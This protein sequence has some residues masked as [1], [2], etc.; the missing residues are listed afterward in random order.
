MDP[1]TTTSTALYIAAAAATTA[2]LMWLRISRRSAA[3]AAAACRPG[4]AASSSTAASVSSRIAGTDAPC[5]V[6]MQQMLK[7]APAPP[8]SLAQGIVHWQPPAAALDAARAALDLP[9]TSAYG[10]DDG[11]PDLR[12]K[13]V[14]KLRDE[15]GLT[16][17]EVMVTTGANQAFVNVVLSLLDAG[18]KA[19]LFK[20][21]YFNH[22]MAL[23]MTGAGQ[24]SREVRAISVLPLFGLQFAST[25][26]T[27]RV[28]LSGS[29]VRF[30]LSLVGV[31]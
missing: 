21:Y 7:N 3:A 20:P 14:E 22:H 15:N 28:D 18:D 2:T 1:A 27:P 13:L 31:C 17:S 9:Q 30:F 23:Q 19:V 24:P 6:G 29:S 26:A 25:Q 8:L 10:P 4:A 11:H 5:I 16:R 12:A